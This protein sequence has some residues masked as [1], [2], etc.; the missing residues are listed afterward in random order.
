[1]GVLRTSR[2]GM[3]GPSQRAWV[4]TMNMA[5]ESLPF[6]PRLCLGIH[7][8]MELG[9]ALISRE[10]APVQISGRAFKRHSELDL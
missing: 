6:E 5:Q 7:P 4:S 1:M 9:P 10:E 2:I 3:T 8:R